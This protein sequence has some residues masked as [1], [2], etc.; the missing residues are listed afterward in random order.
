MQRLPWRAIMRASFI[1]LLAVLLFALLGRLATRET[2]FTYPFDHPGVLHE[3][4]SAVYSS[5]PHWWLDSGGKLIVADGLGKTLHGELP[6]HDP[7]RTRYARTSSGDTVGGRYPQNLFRLV[8]QK[9]SK[10]ARAELTFRVMHDNPGAGSNESNG[11]L[12]MLRYQDSD[13]LYYAGVRVD[14]Q[15][16]IKKKTAG[17]YHTLALEKIF[18]GSFAPGTNLLPHATWLTIAAH[19]TGDN[20]VVISLYLKED[21][22]W[23]MIAEA[24]DSGIGGPPIVGTYPFGIRADFM[25]VEFDSFSLTT[26]GRL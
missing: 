26:V 5:S 19:I 4:E 6:L 24:R 11:V 14:G 15:A 22:G 16:V 18:P 7:W 2:A 12:L 23:R 17:T 10:N 3:S 8:T 9:K 25:D 21:A 20:D 1:A 13:N